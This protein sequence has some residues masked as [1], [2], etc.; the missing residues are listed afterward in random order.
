MN[1]KPTNPDL[2][3][4]PKNQSFFAGVFDSITDGISVLDANLNIV[5]VNETMRKWYPHSLPVDGKKCYKAYHGR[6]EAC[7]SCPVLQAMETGKPEECVTSFSWEKGPTGIMEISA[8]PMLNEA[9]VPVQAVA[10][11]RDITERQQSLT[12]LA[13]NEELYRNLFENS[14]L[15]LGIADI[16]VSYT[17]LRAH[18]T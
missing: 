17:H 14:P 13:E 9:G 8:F 10:Y 5:G 7:E 6:V 3:M 2:E 1:K 4:R 16:A 15:G 12:A 11:V 18:E